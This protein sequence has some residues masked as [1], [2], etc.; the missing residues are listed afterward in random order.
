MPRWKPSSRS[1]GPIERASGAK[2]RGREHVELE[3]AVAVHELGVGEEVD[4]VVHVHVEGAEQAVVLPGAPLEQ[5]ARLDLARLAEVVDEQVAHLPAVAHLLDHDP[6]DAL[7]VVVGGRGLEQVALLLDGGEFGVALVDD[8]VQE[9]VADGLVGD[10]GDPLPLLLPREVAELDLVGLQVSVLGLELRSRENWAGAGRCPSATRGRRRSSRRRWR[11]SS[12]HTQPRI[13][14][15]YA[16]DSALCPEARLDGARGSTGKG[17]IVGF[18]SRSQQITHFFDRE[19]GDVEQ[20]LVRDAARHAR[21]R[22]DPRYVAL[23]RDE[24]E[25]TRGDL[26]EFLAQCEDAA[27]RR[28]LSRALAAA[29]PAT[30]YRE[31]APA[32]SRRRRRDSSSSRSTRPSSG[33]RSGWPR[34]AFRSEAGPEESGDRRMGD[35][36]IG[37]RLGRR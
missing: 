30:V 4:P 23:P 14:P 19:T 20:V 1:I 15:I 2:R 21:V 9:G 8:Q 35:R 27:C 33:R 16:V 29:D 34:R 37:R 36:V 13:I 25:R 17:L 12:C 3:L 11:S 5:L 6:A 32:L 7:G 22:G 10:L 28:D 24:G 18:E 31:V 26:E